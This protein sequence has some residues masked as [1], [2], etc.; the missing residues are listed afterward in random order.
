MHRAQHG[1]AEILRTVVADALKETGQGR[2]GQKYLTD[3]SRRVSSAPA[4]LVEVLVDEIVRSGYVS[5]NSFGVATSGL[6][7]I[8]VEPSERR[9]GIGSALYRT[10]NAEGSLELWAKPGDRTAKSFA[11][12]LGLKARLLVMSAEP[13]KAD[14]K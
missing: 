1:D 4:D 11:E 9:R 6:A 12:A 13:T 7:L 14:E 2:G 8:Y 3:L 5:G 10:I